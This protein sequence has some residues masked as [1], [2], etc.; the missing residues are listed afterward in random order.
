MAASVSPLSS[1]STPLRYDSAAG[2]LSA[3]LLSVSLR[4]LDCSSG[5]SAPPS[6][7]FRAPPREGRGQAAAA[8]LGPEPSRAHAK[9]PTDANDDGG[10]QTPRTCFRS[11]ASTFAVASTLVTG[12]DLR[13]CRL[14]AL[15][16][17]FGCTR[18][19]RNGSIPPVYRF[20]PELQGRWHAGQKNVDRWA[21]TIRT[22]WAAPHRRHSSPARW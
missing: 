16:L 14:A 2:E 3:L 4:L 7:P 6:S 19:L 10:D 11:S 5:F 13:Q 9:K 15:I 1:A 8:G 20:R 17:S 21:W 18:L 22:I 12:A